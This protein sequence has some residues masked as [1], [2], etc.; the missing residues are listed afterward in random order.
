MISFHITPLFLFNLYLIFNG[1]NKLISYYTDEVF[2][3][4]CWSEVML[5]IFQ[6]L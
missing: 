3:K 1:E 4:L 2:Q 5:Q 6:D